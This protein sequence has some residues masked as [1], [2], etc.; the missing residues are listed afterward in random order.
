MNGPQAHPG[1]VNRCV[2]AVREAA[3][4]A[5]TFDG[6]LSREP[7]D[8]GV[9]LSFSHPGQPVRS[10]SITVEACDGGIRL[11]ASRTP[12]GE[13]DAVCVYEGPPKPASALQAAMEAI[14][15]WYGDEVHRLAHT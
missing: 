6:R 5:S 11:T 7:I 4:I 9:R 15:R 2:E 14:G 3:D 12:E 8:G 13:A 1:E 10:T